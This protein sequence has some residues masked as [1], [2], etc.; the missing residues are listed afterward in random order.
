MDE[1]TN[2]TNVQFYWSM[3]SVDLDEDIGQAL[4]AEI[5]QLWLTVRGFSTAGAL[6]NNTGRQLISPQKSHQAYE[7]N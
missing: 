3:I 1:V 5:A 6:A 4:L 2:D 7:R